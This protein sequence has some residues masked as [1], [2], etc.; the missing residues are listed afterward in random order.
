MLSEQGIKTSKDFITGKGKPVLFVLF[1][2]SK[3]QLV[4]DNEKELINKCVKIL[5][6]G[7]RF[8]V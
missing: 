7:A 8:V 3:V 6:Q 2:Y 1:F 4:W 5:N